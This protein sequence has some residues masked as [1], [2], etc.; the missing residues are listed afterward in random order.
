MCEEQIPIRLL[1]GHA[2]L[3][4]QRV[5]TQTGDFSVNPDMVF[6][7]IP[8]EGSV[9]SL[10][11]ASTRHAYSCYY[12]PSRRR[13]AAK[14]RRHLSQMHAPPRPSTLMASQK[15]IQQIQRRRKQ[16]N[17]LLRAVTRDEDINT[18][19]GGTGRETVCPVCLIVVRGDGD[20]VEAHV[21]ACLAHAMT[22]AD[23]DAEDE[24]EDGTPI[25]ATDDVN[26]TSLGIHTR[27]LDAPDDDTEI[28]VEG[29]GAD[30]AFGEAQFTEGDLIDQ[31]PPIRAALATEA[32]DEEDMGK[33]LRELVATGKVVQKAPI[34]DFVTGG[35]SAVNSVDVDKLELAVLA[36]KRNGDTTAL[37]KALEDKVAHLVSPFS[38]S[39]CTETE[40][41]S[42]RKVH[43]Y[44]LV[45]SAS[46]HTWSQQPQQAAGTSHVKNAG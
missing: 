32:V 29:E 34:G 15:T 4:L 20:V 33:T 17:T 14:A 24:E 8:D 39:Q 10:F 13:S 25:R 45:E 11:T 9:P 43:Q 44:Q 7:D 18:P 38:T 41:I 36:A 42:H 27:T 12:R 35:S 5:I 40:D 19:S 3:E 22:Q 30:G 21:D 16:R 46:R 23:A 1:A 37:V 2:A 31:A 26:L 28:D 6:D